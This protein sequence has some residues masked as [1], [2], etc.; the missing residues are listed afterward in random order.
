M[1]SFG[2]NKDSSPIH[3]RRVPAR[4]VLG[5]WSIRPPPYCRGPARRARPGTAAPDHHSREGFTRN[6]GHE[7]ITFHSNH[8]PARLL[9]RLEQFDSVVKFRDRERYQSN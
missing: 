2:G 5:R 8:Q 6:Q 4:G 3:P 9:P 1:A 7:L